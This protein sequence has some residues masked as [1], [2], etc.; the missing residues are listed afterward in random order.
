MNYELELA[1]HFVACLSQIFITQKSPI[2]SDQNAGH[3]VRNTNP[4]NPNRYFS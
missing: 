3:Y 2:R 4:V 1:A